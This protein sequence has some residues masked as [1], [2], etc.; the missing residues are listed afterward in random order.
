[1]ESNDTQNRS[2]IDSSKRE[3]VSGA[4]GPIGREDQIHIEYPT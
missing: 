3:L 1:M 4:H 2:P